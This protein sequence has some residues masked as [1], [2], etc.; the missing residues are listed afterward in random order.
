MSQFQKTIQL[1]QQYKVKLPD[2]IIAATALVHGLPILT[3]NTRDFKAF[4]DL[5]VLNPVS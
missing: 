2:A 1:R 3:R 4:T 5:V